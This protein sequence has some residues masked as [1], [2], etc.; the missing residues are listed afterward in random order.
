MD[1]TASR[2]CRSPGTG[3][4]RTPSPRRGV[5]RPAA[6]GLGRPRRPQPHQGPPG[7]HA[8]LPLVLPDGHLRQLRHDGERRAEADLRDLPGRLRARA[9]PRRATADFPVIRDLV[10]DI[11]D[12][13][14]K[15]PQVKP[16]IVRED[17]RPV[18]RGRVPADAGSSWTTTRSSACAS[19]AC[20][21]TRP[22]PCMA[23]TPTSSVRRRSRWRSAT[24]STRATRA[25]TSAW[26]CSSTPRASGA[27]PS[28]ASAPG[29]APRAS[30]RR[31]LSSGTSSLRRC[32]R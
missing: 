5:R 29:P 16:W 11:G 14:R 25:P 19:T 27:A 17:E 18:F 21:A 15:L 8:V 20:C 13:L 3:R 9:D 24:T 31:A 22:A 7:R 32:T 23:S 6:Q 10:V 4:T 26:T 12:F 30:T 2:R 28:S 1:D